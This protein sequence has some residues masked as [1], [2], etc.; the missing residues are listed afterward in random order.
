MNKK[1]RR[2]IGKVVDAQAMAESTGRKS[3]TA[4]KLVLE[5]ATAMAHELYDTMMQDNNWYAL[6]KS[7]HPEGTGAKDLEES[8]VKRNTPRLLAGARSVLAQ[9]LRTSL[10]PELRDEIHDALLLDA[11]LVAPERRGVKGN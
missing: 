1:E 8:F 7:W 2:K 4:H 3:G 9:M 10:S 5:T 6:W 11:T